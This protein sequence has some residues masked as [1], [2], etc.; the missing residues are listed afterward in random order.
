[1][2]ARRCN[3]QGSDFPLSQRGWLCLKSV[4][5][6]AACWSLRLQMLWQQ[7]I[8]LAARRGLMMRN[9]DQRI[10][11]SNGTVI[12]IY[13]IMPNHIK[14]G[15]LWEIQLWD[16]L[17]VILERRT[18]ERQFNG[19]TWS[20]EELWKYMIFYI[21][22]WSRWNKSHKYVRCT[23]RDSRIRSVLKQHPHENMNP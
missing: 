20:L 2:S 10:S 4:L 7:S 19:E 14:V 6:L 18:T 11:L 16:K 13:A 17:E 9:Q 23:V 21:L 5:S 3:R 15:E 22:P 12:T 8:M 1:M